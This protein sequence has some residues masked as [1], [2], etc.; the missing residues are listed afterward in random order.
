M[1]KLFT[2][3]TVFASTAVFAQSR[4]IPNDTIVDAEKTIDAEY[5]SA[6]VYVFY[7]D[8]LGVV[9]VFRKDTN[10]VSSNAMS[11]Y[12]VDAQRNKAVKELSER[13]K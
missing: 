11:G 3:L 1:K 12:A 10:V 6:M 7:S 13:V 2:I 4:F 9:P 5:Y 8:S